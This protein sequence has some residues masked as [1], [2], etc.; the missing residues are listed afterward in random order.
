M[1]QPGDRHRA[2]LPFSLNTVRVFLLQDSHRFVWSTVG[3]VEPFSRAAIADLCMPPSPYLMA[4]R[5]QV[6]LRAHMLVCRP[7]DEQIWMELGKGSIEVWRLPTC[8]RNTYLVPR[9]WAHLLYLICNVSKQSHRCSSVEDELVLMSSSLCRFSRW[10][11]NVRGEY[12]IQLTQ[13]CKYAGEVKKEKAGCPRIV[14][15]HSKTV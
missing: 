2:S 9:T 7:F 12:G 1:R 10:E 15:E 14:R 8:R 6:H 11:G 3:N 13:V 5:H 4:F